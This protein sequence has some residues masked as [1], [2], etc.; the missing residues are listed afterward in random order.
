[1]IELNGKTYEDF[2]DVYVN[3]DYVGAIM[4]GLKFY[5]GYEETYCEHHG[6]ETCECE[7]TE[8]CFTV[9]LD[10]KELLRLRRSEIE[11][12]TATKLEEPVHYLLLGIMIFLSK[13]HK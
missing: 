10:D 3:D 12:K 2:L 7:D 8:W 9:T 11:E 13:P 1:M 5:Y 6:A 4:N